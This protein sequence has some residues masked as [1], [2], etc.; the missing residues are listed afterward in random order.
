MPADLVSCAWA[1]LLSPLAAAALILLAGV[2]RP[3]LSAAAAIAGLLTGF[4]CAVR[5]FLHAHGR[6]DALLFESSVS[7]IALPGLTI[8]FGVLIDPLSLLMALIVTG[9]GSLIFIYAAGYMAED[10]AVSRFYGLLSLFAF[11]ML[12]IVLATNWIQLFIG[13]ELVGF[14]SYMLIGHWYAK[15]S[16]AEAGKKAFMV[17]RVADF[18]FMLGILAL[19]AA[20]SPTVSQRS[21]HFLTLERQL[22]SAIQAG[23]IPAGTLTLIGL[24]LFCGPLGKS[25]QFPLH[26]WLPD[27]MEGP[28]PVSALI[29]AATMVAAGVYLLCRAFWLFSGLPE[30]MTV[31]MW[32]GGAT[33]FLSAC[34]ALVENDLKR[35]LAYS[36]LSQ[37]GY[38]VMAVG[39]GG[40]A[41]GMYHLGTHAFFKALL[42]LSAGSVMHAT[43][44]LDIWK[45]GGLA[46]SMRWT[47]ACFLVGA[48]ALAGFPGLSGFFSKD[49]ILVLAR[50]HHL[51]IYVLAT[52][53]AGLTAFYTAR[54][55]FVA[56]TGS[57]RLSTR[58]GA[59]GGHHG[60]QESPPIMLVPL[61]VLAALSVAGGYLGIPRF[62]GASH[63]EFHWD[64]AAT[65]VAAALTGLTLAW[66]I[67]KRQAVS[68][69]QVVQALA[70]PYSF[71][72]RRYWI[73]E[74]YG[75]YV[76]TV[77]QKLI[78]GLCAWVERV[79]IIG[80]AVNGTAWLTRGAGL[81]LRRCQTGRVQTY[82][83]VFLIGVAGLLTIA[84]TR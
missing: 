51:G 64:V 7:W 41:E 54:V 32:V 17:N 36:T 10:A 78:A 48:L 62:L 2:H 42:F 34:L 9:V 30:V 18:G 56:F 43:H 22:S 72:Q 40:R 52:L 15:P 37:L 38:M 50:G 31:I 74:M 46:R 12:T 3:K 49:E 45:L 77:Q 81:L 44:E 75:W 73:D 21:F 5:L 59:G 35:I 14:S 63:A 6:H 58:H 60:V 27:A 11:S 53:T 71:L 66:L 65:S 26:V 29:H 69:Q 8:P 25:A 33:A 4:L 39:L 13:W 68:A 55:W 47:S 24:L 20:S 61:F 79:V 19:W 76:A 70:L 28:T 83:F 1:I 23:L 80:A 16:A 57:S 84:L 67:Y 82:V